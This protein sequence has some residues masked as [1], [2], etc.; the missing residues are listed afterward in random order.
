MYNNHVASSRSDDSSGQGLSAEIINRSQ[1]DTTIILP[2]PLLGLLNDP[3]LWERRCPERRA[4]GIDQLDPQS[5]I[6]LLRDIETLLSKVQ[7][8]NQLDLLQL[9]LGSPEPV[10]YPSPA[11][12]AYF[13]FVETMERHQG[14]FIS[15][16][17]Q[18][19]S[20]VL[21]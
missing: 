19:I 2:E 7:K 17:L 15:E 13:D 12:W 8:L 10:T 5:R 14:V 20:L 21:K 3:R 18:E 9:L 11:E 1:A 6:L 4:H 16:M